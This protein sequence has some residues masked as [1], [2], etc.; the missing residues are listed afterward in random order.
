MSNITPIADR[1][2][3]F[4]AFLVIPLHLFLYLTVLQAILVTASFFA[5]H[6][7]AIWLVNL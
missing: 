1:L 2:S 4:A 7:N 5:L 6:T 3:S